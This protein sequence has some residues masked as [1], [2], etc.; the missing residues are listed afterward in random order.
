MAVQASTY[1][2][3]RKLPEGQYRSVAETD[4]F[5]DAPFRWML[6][7]AESPGSYAVYNTFSGKRVESVP[8]V[9]YPC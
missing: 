8:S 4:S 5:E 3:F 9:A 2:V 1:Y 6:L 7:E